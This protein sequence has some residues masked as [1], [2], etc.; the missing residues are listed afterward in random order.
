M[1]NGKKWGKR[2]RG[3]SYI[4]VG[5]ARVSLGSWALLLEQ[6]VTEHPGTLWRREIVEKDN[7]NFQ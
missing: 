7:A 5:S 1:K 4:D 3:S 6:L 2:K